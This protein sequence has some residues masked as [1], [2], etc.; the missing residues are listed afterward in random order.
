MATNKLFKLAMLITAV[1][2]ILA[3]MGFSVDQ[4]GTAHADYYSGTCDQP[5]RLAAGGQ[6]RVT[7]YPNQPNRIR[8]TPDFNAQVV[9][10]IPVGAT[11]S[12]VNGPYCAQGT[13][14]FLVSYNGVTGWTGEG[15]GYGTYWLEPVYSAPTCALPNRLVVGS[16]GRVTPGL[17]NVVRTAPGTSATGA[18]SVVIGEIPAGGI[19]YVLAGPVCGSD[20]RPWWQVNYNGLTGWTAEGEGYGSYWVEPYHIGPNPGTC[21][22]A[23][24]PRLS[25]GMTGRVTAWP[26][27][28]N[29]IR[30][31]AGYGNSVIGWI[32]AGATFSVLS[33]PVCASGGNWYQVSYHGVTGW[34]V[35]GSSIYYLEPAW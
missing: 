28:P 27:L 1:V 22:G 14:W 32:P 13:Q 26:P 33:G 15:N 17:P 35:E 24:T 16:Y 2:M 21:A 10:Y 4:I 11:F 20:G 29:R 31:N 5:S 34:T 19:F 30:S 3:G 23:L 8:T 9:G 7:L 6:G 25:A 12:V 18:N